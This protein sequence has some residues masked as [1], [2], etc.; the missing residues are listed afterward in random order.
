ML[1]AAA[2]GVSREQNQDVLKNNLLIFS[3][4]LRQNKSY[5]K[6][7][8]CGSGAEYDKSRPLKKIKETAWGETIPH[9]DYGLGKYLASQISSQH[10]KVLILRFFG[11]FG[12]YENFKQRFISQNIINYITKKDLAINQNCYFDFL[13]I[14]DLMPILDWFFTHKHKYQAYNIGS[15]QR[16]SLLQIARQINSLSKHKAKI[17]LKN[18]KLNLEYSCDIAR[19]QKEIKNLQ[20]TPLDLSLPRLYNWYQQ[21]QLW[22]KN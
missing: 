9:D 5:A 12:E 21:H 6:F 11:L 22:L 19:L 4:L 10:S 16:I 1:N 17:I 8:Q 3:N 20:F 13:D 2:T 7:I 14:L 18:K 15:G